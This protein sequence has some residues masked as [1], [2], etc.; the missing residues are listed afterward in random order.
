V[1]D[2]R[3]IECPRL[4]QAPLQFDDGLMTAPAVRLMMEV[5][6]VR[7]AQIPG[8]DAQAPAARATGLCSG[9]TKD[10]PGTES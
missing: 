5:D 4:F 1:L 8:V 3:R 9:T 2:A 7:R 10:C 6:D